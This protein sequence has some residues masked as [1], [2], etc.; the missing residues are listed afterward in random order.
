MIGEWPKLLDCAACGG[1]QWHSKRGCKVCRELS[2]ASK[3]WSK[4]LTTAKR[5]TTARVSGIRRRPQ[6]ADRPKRANRPRKKRD[7]D[8]ARAE[9]LLWAKFARYVKDRDGN[10]CF[11]CG[12]EGLEG[13]GWQAGHMHSADRF[14]ILRYHPLNVHSQCAFCNCGLSGNGAAYASHFL[15]VYGPDQLLY[16]NEIKREQKQWKEHELL[17][18]VDAL[19]AGPADYELK[20]MDL[21]GHVLIGAHA[22]PYSKLDAAQ[23]VDAGPIGAVDESTT[24]ENESNQSGAEPSGDSTKHKLGSTN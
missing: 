19:E 3:A 15:E 24:S 9:R 2:R 20:Y 12:K 14:G 16:L 22:S 5:I 4:P 13:R 17:E 7:S 18:L 1:R 8:L 21:I 23:A 6:K 11:S 10:T